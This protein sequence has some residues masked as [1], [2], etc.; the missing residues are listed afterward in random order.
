MNDDEST[1]ALS[2]KVLDRSNVMQFLAPE[3]FARPAEGHAPATPGSRSFRNGR[4]GS[5]QPTRLCGGDR[6]KAR[7]VI[8]LAGQ[9]MDGSAVPSVT[10]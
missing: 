8:R 1:Q 3:Q 9:V 10:G 6:D 5:G 4:N 2:D 7:R